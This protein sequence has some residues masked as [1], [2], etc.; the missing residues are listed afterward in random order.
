MLYAIKIFEDGFNEVIDLFDVGI[1][2]ALDFAENWNIKKGSRNSY[3]KSHPIPSLKSPKVI[4]HDP[5]KKFNSQIPK[6]KIPNNEKENSSDFGEK[7]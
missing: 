6:I 1:F 5:K 2:E 3:N 7:L 4:N